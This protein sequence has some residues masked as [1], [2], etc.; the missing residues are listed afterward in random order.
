[1]AFDLT[2]FATFHA[3][4][5]SSTCCVVGFFAVTTLKSDALQRM[6]IGSLHEQSATDPLEVKIVVSVADLD[7]EQTHVRF[8]VEC[9]ARFGA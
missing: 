8:G 2:N 4:I 6:V 1:M 9:R 5:K 3:N 7:R